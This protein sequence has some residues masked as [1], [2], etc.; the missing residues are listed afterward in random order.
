MNLTEQESII[1]SLLFAAGEVVAKETL[2]SIQN[3][4]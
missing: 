2:T 4:I 3:N 1:E